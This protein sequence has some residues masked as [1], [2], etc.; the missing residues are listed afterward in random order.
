V[1]F[2][3]INYY[4]RH[5]AAGPTDGQFSDPS[6][7]SAAPGSERV[8]MV[9][10][11]APKTAMGWEIHPDGLVDVIEMVHD[12][13]PDLPVYITENGAAY[14]DEVGSDGQI[15]DEE[16]RRYFEQHTAACAEALQRLLPLK[17]YFAWSLLDNW[18]WAFG[19]SRR[20]GLVYVDYATQQ[21]TVKQSGAWFRDLLTDSNRPSPR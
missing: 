19:L 12:R 15:A 13:A 21:R 18:E 16:R 20:F 8:V 14:T 4:S 3:G 11:G 9:D 10:T 2:L 6:V 1:D 5:T 7:P 17:G